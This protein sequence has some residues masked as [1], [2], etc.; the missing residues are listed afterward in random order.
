MAVVAADAAYVT[1]VAAEGWSCSSSA[2]S[3][4][5]MRWRK[6][7]VASLVV[8]KAAVARRVVEGATIRMLHLP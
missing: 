1:K 6:V 5:N 7:I 4:K 8:V 2:K 3:T